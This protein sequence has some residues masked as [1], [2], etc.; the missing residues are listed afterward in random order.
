MFF[1][2]GFFLLQ[3]D[4]YSPLVIGS[5]LTLI[6]ILQEDDGDY[7][8]ELHATFS[9]ERNKLHQTLVYRV[10][11]HNNTGQWMH[12]R[13][14]AATGVGRGPGRRGQPITTDTL[15]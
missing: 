11:M 6:S 5:V 7:A 3:S 13:G 9:A 14:W 8:R 10:P 2:T 1:K 4:V 15:L 12:V